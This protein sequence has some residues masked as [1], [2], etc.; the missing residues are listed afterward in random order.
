M[1][2][3]DGYFFFLPIFFCRLQ[4]V[5][6]S[7]IARHCCLYMCTIVNGEKNLVEPE[8]RFFFLCCT[9]ELCECQKNVF[10][11]NKKKKKAEKKIERD[12]KCN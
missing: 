4:T 2:T 7:Q 12:K 10:E 11:T 6:C 5:D 9:F 3:L 8:R 1:S